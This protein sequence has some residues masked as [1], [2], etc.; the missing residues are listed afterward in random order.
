M[1]GLALGFNHKGTI[2]FL[3]ELGLCF[4]KS[5]LDQAFD[6]FD[7]AGLVVGRTAA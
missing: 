1:T 2:V 7:I 4:F 6:A 5:S 3:A